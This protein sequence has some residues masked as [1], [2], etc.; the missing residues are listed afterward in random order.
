[1][2]D[3]AA[4]SSDIFSMTGRYQFRNPTAMLKAT[5]ARWTQQ[6]VYQYQRLEILLQM[7]HWNCPLEMEKIV[8]IEMGMRKQSKLIWIGQEDGIRLVKWLQWEDHLQRH[9]DNLTQLYHR[10][11]FCISCLVVLP[12]R[13]ALLAP[14]FSESVLSITSQVSLGY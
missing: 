6:C 11:V 7:C 13:P 1:M 14:R 10:P 2:A 3:Q 4:I 12:Q 8:V 5:L 9:S